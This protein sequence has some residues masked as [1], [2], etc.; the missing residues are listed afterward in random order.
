MILAIGSLPL[1]RI[2]AA[3]M[4][5]FFPIYWCNMG[6][7]VLIWPPAGLLH[8]ETNPFQRFFPVLLHLWKGAKLEVK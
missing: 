2:L 7:L 1:L 6:F 4:F 8:H 3:E 5:F